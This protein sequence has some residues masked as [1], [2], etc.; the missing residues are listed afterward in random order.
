M[1]V[2]TSG[3]V[4]EASGREPHSNHSNVRMTCVLGVASRLTMLRREKPAKP[5]IAG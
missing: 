2:M 5:A 4:F 1:F 3:R